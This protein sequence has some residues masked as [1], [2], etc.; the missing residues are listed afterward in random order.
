M[1]N[2][3]LSL[4]LIALCGPSVVAQDVPSGLPGR[5][6]E[7][8]I[9]WSIAHEGCD[10][11]KGDELRSSSDLR[12]CYLSVEA[13]NRGASALLSEA[14]PGVIL[15]A[16]RRATLRAKDEYK[17]AENFQEVLFDVGEFISFS[18]LATENKFKKI[19]NKYKEIQAHNP[20]AR[21]VL[22]ALKDSEIRALIGDE[23]K[24]PIYWEVASG[25]A[26]GGNWRILG[27]GASIPFGEELIGHIR[28]SIAHE[29]CNVYDGDRVRPVEAL[30]S[31]YESAEVE[32]SRARNLLT[33]APPEAIIQATRAAVAQVKSESGSVAH[34]NWVLIHEGR[35]DQFRELLEKK[36][37]MEIREDYRMLQFHNPN[38]RNL[39]SAFSDSELSTMIRQDRITLLINKDATPETLFAVAD[40]ISPEKIQLKQPTSVT[41]LLEKHYAVWTMRYVGFD[42]GISGSLDP[43][44]DKG[45]VQPGTISLPVIPRPGQIVTVTLRQGLTYEDAKTVPQN[46]T[47]QIAPSRRAELLR[48]VPA[49]AGRPSDPSSSQDER[50]YGTA[51]GADK[52]RKS[53]LNLISEAHIA[54]IDA[55]VD[56]NHPLLKPVFWKLPADFSGNSW[57]PE[58]MGYNYLDGTSDPTEQDSS[59]SHGTHVTGLVTGRMLSKSDW[60][61]EIHRVGLERFV[62]AYSLKITEAAGAVDFSFP[63]QAV[64]D[65]IDND[66]H[67]LNLSLS[68]WAFPLLQTKLAAAPEKAL[69]VVAAGEVP[70]DL[71]NDKTFDGAFRDAQG[72]C[73]KNVILVAALG[74]NGKGKK[75]WSDSNS[76]NLVVQIAAP[77]EAITSTFREGSSGQLS[78]TSQAA[79]FVT[80][81]AGILWAE[82]P[83]SFASRIKSRILSTCDWVP[84]LEDAVVAGCRLNMAK[85][86]VATADIIELKDG[87]WIRGTI[88]K[89]QFHLHPSGSSDQTLRTETLER[90]FVKGANGTVQVGVRGLAR[91]EATID[92]KSI[93]IDLQAG[94]ACPGRG[95]PSCTIDTDQISDIVFRWA[96]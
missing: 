50:W 6:L 39:L 14:T 76:G 31:C 2:I 72:N 29:G 25:S 75:L 43:F 46:S 90:V 4:C 64:A 44:V 60:F 79:P 19:R 55:G 92:Q 73:L 61:P 33:I 41:S 16:T 74:S 52:V 84:E 63:S 47:V 34:M 65:A 38:A 82:S 81:T 10:V 23:K 58:S 66:V 54:V 5:D 28:W 70:E 85:A 91:Q 42:K 17:I 26:Q 68:G 18:E 48:S 77:G 80:L 62:K 87:T 35:L 3:R 15:N 36:R 37:F 13:H 9:V 93:R 67:L 95:G 94:E 96:N 30:R 20:N 88:D 12:S 86:I 51:I 56:M 8:H 78:G 7:N 49:L 1:V 89:K 53:D 59:Y 69:L 71:N 21:N 11:Y 32:N 83:G 27:E 22:S 45:I 40:L 57:P 24:W